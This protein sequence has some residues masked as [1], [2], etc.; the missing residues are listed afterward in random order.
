MAL[1]CALLNAEQG[2]VPGCIPDYSVTPSPGVKVNERTR[3]HEI[4]NDQEEEK[5]AE[6][7]IIFPGIRSSGTA[8]FLSQNYLFE[9]LFFL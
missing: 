4:Q 3:S 6:L 7:F 1:R 8:L 9:N 2:S 5:V